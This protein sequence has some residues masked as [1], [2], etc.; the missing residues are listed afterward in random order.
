MDAAKNITAIFVWEGI[1]GDVDGNGSANS[2]DAL[3]VLSADVGIS[4]VPYCPMNCG[5]VNGNGSVNSTDALILLSFDVGIPV[6]F[7]IGTM[8]CPQTVTQPPGCSQ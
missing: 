8:G 5:D 4:V 1:L 7:A 3:I 6:P 2:T